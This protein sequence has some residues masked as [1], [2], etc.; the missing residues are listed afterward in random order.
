MCGEERTWLTTSQ[1]RT[2]RQRGLG[3]SAVMGREENGGQV[4]ASGIQE[5]EYSG[6]GGCRFH[7]CSCEGHRVICRMFFIL[8]FKNLH[9]FKKDIC[10]EPEKPR[11]LMFFKKL[12][13]SSN[14]HLVFSHEIR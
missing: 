13:F 9:S 8:F 2:P 14:T 11:F 3:N 10:F 1:E 7:I 4:W 5:K 6:R 12:I